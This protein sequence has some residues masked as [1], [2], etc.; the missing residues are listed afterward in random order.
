MKQTIQS[1]RLNHLKFIASSTLRSHGVIKEQQLHGLEQFQKKGA[2]LRE[3][4]AAIKS[5]ADAAKDY[6][7]FTANNTNAKILIEGPFK[8]TYSLAIVN[9]SLAEAAHSSTIL[10]LT[11]TSRNEDISGDSFCANSKAISETYA[12]DRAPE[13][14]LI[15]FNNW[16]PSISHLQGNSVGLCCFAWEE[17]QFP[18]RYTREFNDHLSFACVTS[19]FVRD[20][21]VNSGVTVPIFICGNGITTSNDHASNI[22][23]AY[24]EKSKQQDGPVFTFLHI[25][26]GFPRKGVDV[27]VEAFCREFR[28][29]EPVRLVI[30]S[31]NNPHNNLT[32]LLDDKRRQHSNCADISLILEDL[33]IEDLN[34]L[35][36]SA[37]AVVYPTRGEGFLLPA[38]EA[39]IHGLPVLTTNFGGQ[40]DFCNAEN[41]ILINGRLTCSNSHVGSETSMWLEPDLCS[42]REAM[43]R[44]IQ[45]TPLERSE[46]AKRLRTEIE[47]KYAWDS[48]WKRTVLAA[49]RSKTIREWE[50]AGC[51]LL[52][53]SSW[54]QKCGIATYCDLLVRHMAQPNIDMSLICHA[55]PESEESK[56]DPRFSQ[57]TPNWRPTRD[58]LES[59]VEAIKKADSDILLIQHH[60]GQYSYDD[61]CKFISAAH[62]SGKYTIVELHSSVRDYPFTTT[63]SEQL[64]KCWRVIVHTMEEMSAIR[65]LCTKTRT[66]L[67]TH[68]IRSI[69]SYS[70]GAGEQSSMK[71]P[72]RAE[73][74]YT[75]G[76]FGFA[77]P[78]KGIDSALRAISHIKEAGPG[79]SCRIKLMCACNGTEKTKRHIEEIQNLIKELAISSEVILDTGFHEIKHV[80]Q[81]LL[82]TDCLVFPYEES[83]ESASGAIR[84]VIGLGKPIIVSEASI[85]DEF[86]E[87][88]WTTDA[89]DPELFAK[90]IISACSSEDKEHK[91]RLEKQINYTKEN[92]WDARAL[93]YKSIIVAAMDERRCH[94]DLVTTVPNLSPERLITHGSYFFV[95]T[96]HDTQRTH[97]M[98]K[99]VTYFLHAP[100]T[101]GSSMAK[102]LLNN[103]PSLCSSLESS[104]NIY[105]DCRTNKKMGQI[106]FG[107]I[108]VDDIF[109]AYNPESVDKIDLSI[110][111]ILRE[112]VSRCASNLTFWWKEMNESPS[113]R[114]NYVQDGVNWSKDPIEFART[115]LIAALEQGVTASWKYNELINPYT[116]Q[117]S[118]NLYA[119]RGKT[120]FEAL[121][122]AQEN[123]RRF[124]CIEFFEEL[125]NAHDR[126]LRFIAKRHNWIQET[127]GVTGNQ[128]HEKIGI[129]KVMGSILDDKDIVQMISEI[130]KCDTALYQFCFSG[131]E[132]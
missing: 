80:Y 7:H 15:L 8:G 49:S 123:L 81:E 62:A 93:Q 27:L 67:I 124:D 60:L 78:H 20:A 11:T 16:P 104:D 58:G 3:L 13:A 115:N 88:T 33:S 82:D 129:S 25:S 106:R 56:S 69:Q 41:S 99:R 72:S 77:M 110:V 131:V 105:W 26:S 23:A 94:M 64:S 132:K 51:K 100:R 18:A 119:R 24:P 116:H 91:Q 86:R 63:Q 17:T 21:L 12:P 32:K 75:V 39:A 1:L 73:K 85:F 47:S 113:A 126:I 117:F 96:K 83:S 114:A 50:R 57:I 48:V 102:I 76:M 46:Q 111:T 10:N 101:S 95:P 66:A 44:V 52:L 128:E 74:I 90:M 19:S 92:S 37:H 71:Q 103:F 9:R 59:T 40:S 89:K 79:I 34:D 4:V 118:S 42:L 28:H 120:D 29:D 130:S 109:S 35:Y 122:V 22:Q 97:A 87:M 61:L 14:D 98:Y 54:N 45:M 121:F 55:L 125:P 70:D 84:E 36:R 5:R 30:K 107:H 127:T 68:P 108:S 53:L 6:G 38:A 43:R 112:P 31:F 65:D 2:T